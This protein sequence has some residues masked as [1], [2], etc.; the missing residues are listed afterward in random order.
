MPYV[1]I[2]LLL[3]LGLIY[4]L[5]KLILKKR[6]ERGLGRDVEDRELTSITSWMKAAENESSRK[7]DRE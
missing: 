1:F 6:L 3:I 7:V 5:R 4:W 2:A